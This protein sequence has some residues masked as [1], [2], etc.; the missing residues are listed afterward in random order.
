[1]TIHSQYTRPCTRLERCYFTQT[2]S[3][4]TMPGTCSAKYLLLWSWLAWLVWMF[5]QNVII[6]EVNISNPDTVSHTI[7]KKNSPFFRFG[8]GVPA[9]AEPRPAVPAPGWFLR[10]RDRVGGEWTPFLQ[11]AKN[12]LHANQTPGCLQSI[13]EE[14]LSS[15]WKTGEG[16]YNITIIVWLARWV[17]VLIQ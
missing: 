8:L 5:L 2:C 11:W 16:Y 17:N 12:G 13:L 4:R 3:T 14:E 9:F 15:R 10:V 6:T 7:P 1:M